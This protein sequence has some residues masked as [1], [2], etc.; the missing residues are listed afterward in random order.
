[1]KKY[2]ILDEREGFELISSR[3]DL[4]HIH[5]IEAAVN[6]LMDNGWKPLGGICCL[7]G[8]DRPGL[9]QAMVYG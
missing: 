5:N 1:M 4:G 8:M 9:I 7:S 6:V 2:R 3:Y